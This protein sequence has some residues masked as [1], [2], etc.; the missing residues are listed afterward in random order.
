[1]LHH[2]AIG[3]LHLLFIFPI[4]LA[5]YVVLLSLDGR[6]KE[7]TFSILLAATLITQFLLATETFAT[8]VLFG[9]IAILVFY[10]F[11]NPELR[12]RIAQLVKP[13][14]IGLT[15]VVV[16]LAPYFYYIFALGFPDKPVNSPTAFSV[17]F[18]NFF[19]PTPTLLIGANHLLVKVSNSF[20]RGH[21]EPTGYLSLPILG[22]LI[23]FGYRRWRDLA[24]KALVVFVSV[25]CVL[26]IGPRLHFAGHV[27]PGMPW[28]LA[29][30]LPLLDSALPSR[31]MIYAF[32]ALAVIVSLYMTARDISAI[33]KYAA[34]A[35]IV[36]FSLPNP[37]SEYWIKAN[38]SPEFFTTGIFKQYVSPNENVVVLPYGV[39]GSSMLWQAETDM[40]FR[41]AGGYVSVSPPDV[42]LAWPITNYFL[43][44]DAIPDAE[45]QLKVF[46][47]THDVH[48]V[49]V[50]DKVWPMWKPL[51][52]SLGT[53]P[54][55]AGGVYIYRVPEEVLA[56]YRTLTASE[57]E[58]R[59]DTERFDAL[60]IAAQ[61]YL[62]AGGE[63]SK[64]TPFELQS[65]GL[66][67]PGWVSD[68]DIR[69]RNGLYLAPADD[70]GMS[71]GVTGSYNALKP[72]IERY[73]N[74]ARE[75][76]FPYPGKL[77]EP[78]RGNTFMRLLVMDFS[79]DGLAKAAEA[80]KH[81]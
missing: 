33:W 40:Y 27:G 30:H 18:L 8:L 24:G 64:A 48:T 34:T 21:E 77:A 14:A 58:T 2:V 76:Y 6:I 56:P 73:R 47:A 79:R 22:V 62:S 7:T 80:A 10:T 9:A 74:F 49:L 25:A 28:K 70:D 5:I 53:S 51:L 81:H 23:W 3:H 69:T 41:M 11:A 39:T 38:E 15:L 37:S 26:A 12:E 16:L 60:V 72:T 4:P 32:L 67:P 63:L 44:K 45:D 66:L 57:M 50:T 42:F 36:F 54:Q 17:D 59:L 29:T 78:P 71:V 20:T 1:M 52:D 31:F 13:I 61:Q 43:H 35:L 55:D 68:R 46:L 75:I 19:I 65:R